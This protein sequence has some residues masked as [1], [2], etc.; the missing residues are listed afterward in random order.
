MITLL[1]LV[2]FFFFSDSLVGIRPHFLPKS[3]TT[4][5]DIQTD[6]FVSLSHR[7]SASTINMHRLINAG[8]AL[9]IAFLAFSVYL[10][11]AV[12]T[13]PFA[14]ELKDPQIQSIS[15]TWRNDRYEKFL[16]PP[17]R[18]WRYFLKRCS[19]VRD[20]DDADGLP[21]PS[22][23]VDDQKIKNQ[24]DN[25]QRLLSAACA[26]F[27]DKGMIPAYGQPEPALEAQRPRGWEQDEIYC[28]HYES[29]PDAGAGWI[30]ATTRTEQEFLWHWPM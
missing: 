5:T 16:D 27:R 17:T 7:I 9:G 25:D 1:F 6:F 10:G 4:I 20:H 14:T 15:E 13:T 2:F 8:V 12:L 23:R 18:Q 19:N 24:A 26:C 30:P 29:H 21:P 3:N 28:R 11:I 22:I